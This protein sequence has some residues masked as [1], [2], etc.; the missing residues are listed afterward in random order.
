MASIESKS[1]TIVAYLER[2][3]DQYL[4][5]KPLQ[6]FHFIFSR[7]QFTTWPEKEY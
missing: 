4:C 7:I 2:E 6:P 3:N 1:K 5:Q